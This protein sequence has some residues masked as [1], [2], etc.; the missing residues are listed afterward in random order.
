MADVMVDVQDIDQ[1]DVQI[2]D[3]FRL[4]FN[5]AE[6][7]NPYFPNGETEITASGDHITDIYNDGCKNCISFACA[8]QCLY[9]LPT[10][11]D[12]CIKIN[13]QRNRIRYIESLPKNLEY[14]NC[15]YGYLE[16][17]PFYQNMLNLRHLDI[18]HNLLKA[19]PS[20]P[21]N[22]EYLR[23]DD[24][25]IGRLPQTLPTNLQHLFCNTCQLRE[26]PTE[27]PQTLISLDIR[28]NN[29]THL[30]RSIL[31]CQNLTELTYEYNPRIIVDEDVLEWIDNVFHNIHNNG[32][33]GNNIGT[34]TGQAKPTLYD[35]GQNVHDTKIQKDIYENIQKLLKDKPELKDVNKCLIEF[36][37]IVGFN[38]VFMK[39]VEMCQTTFI[40]SLIGITFGGCFIYVWN[41]IRKSKHKNEICKILYNEI[42]EMKQVCFTGRV[43]RLVNILMGFEEDMKI[44]I[45]INQQINAKYNVVSKA[46]DKLRSMNEHLAYNIACYYHLKEL[47]EEIKVDNNTINVWITPFQDE[48]KDHISKFNAD[49]L[50]RLIPKK[51][52][53]MFII[54]M[55][56]L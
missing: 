52:Y 29:I 21:P 13:V 20:L 53:D 42:P 54:D 35:D 51:Y 49:K 2:I 19:M 43:S 46:Y 30:P 47:L 33:N 3:P 38:E 55:P 25:P 12:T 36:R 18:S 5:E 56:N 4:M 45:D 15:S 10:L 34:A 6:Q 7:F 22:L 8:F 37:N 14:I 40:H 23:C 27:I 31:N 44:S 9:Q 1:A 26:L 39:M 24:N 17:F 32:N 41:R 48:I 11:P 28:H 50:Q 16:F